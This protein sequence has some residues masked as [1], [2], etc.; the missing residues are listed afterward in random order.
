MRKCMCVSLLYSGMLNLHDW[1]GWSVFLRGLQPAWPM[2]LRGTQPACWVAARVIFEQGCSSCMIRNGISA[3][4]T[5][6][7]KDFKDH[8][9]ATKTYTMTSK[10]RL[11]NISVN[12][13]MSGSRDRTGASRRWYGSI[14]KF[15]RMRSRWLVYCLNTIMISM[16]QQ[17]EP[18]GGEA[19]E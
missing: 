17:P 6:V 19:G 8:I 4:L 14:P 9:S 11:R 10:E 13:W 2:F 7:A 18:S 15:V 3:R 12:E 16:V 5:K 1:K